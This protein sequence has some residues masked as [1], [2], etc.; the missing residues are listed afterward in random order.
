MARTANVFIRVEPNIKEQA[1]EVLAQLG[2]PMSN[3]LNPVFHR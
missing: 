1:E 3:V 2:I